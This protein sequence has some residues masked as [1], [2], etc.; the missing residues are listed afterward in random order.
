MRLRMLLG[1]TGCSVALLGVGACTS[2]IAGTASFGG[3]TQTTED[4]TEDTTEETTSDVPTTDSD[5]FLA[6]IT[7][8]F[9][10]D[11][12]LDNF[13]ELADAANNGTTTALTPES[14]AADFDAAIAAVQPVLDPLPPGDVRD[15]IQAAQTGAGGLRDGLRA[16]TA[17]DNNDLID[18]LD[19]LATACDF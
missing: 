17:V 6:C 12:A 3:P 4:T 10:Y 1:T 2:S 7:A 15:A 5:E 8:P 14:V 9:S 16:G 18:A 13:G 11:L 19:S